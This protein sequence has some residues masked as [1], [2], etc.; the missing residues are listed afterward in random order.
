MNKI[1]MILYDE[2]KMCVVIVGHC[3]RSICHDLSLWGW[4]KSNLTWETFFLRFWWRKHFGHYCGLSLMVS[5]SWVVVIDHIIFLIR[6]V[7]F[8]IFELKSKIDD[9]IWVTALP[10][11]HIWRRL[12]IFLLLLHPKTTSTVVYM[13]YTKFHLF[14]YTNLIY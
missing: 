5:L 1:P 3:W 2:G 9:F 10:I 12:L 4:C 13:N 8:V 11:I 14:F 6:I 7:F